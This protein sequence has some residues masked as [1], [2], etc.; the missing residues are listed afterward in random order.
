MRAILAALFI[1]VAFGFGAA[2]APASVARTL[3]QYHPGCNRTADPVGGD[4]AAASHRF[5]ERDV[6][7]Q[8]LG[9]VSGRGSGFRTLK[10]ACVRW[11][12]YD[13]V[14][15]SELRNLHADC[16]APQNAARSEC[17]AAVHRYCERV[18]SAKGGV[19][20]EI[21]PTS[22]AV[23]CASSASYSDVSYRHLYSDASPCR[24]PS[25]G[26]SVMCRAAA[27]SWCLANALG[28]VGLPQEV[29]PQSLGIACLPGTTR[30]IDLAD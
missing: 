3:T 23:A 8:S 20:Q 25:M 15:Y 16:V 13:N 30:F 22:V 29:G 17:V 6:I 5:C 26:N 11:T 1:L 28:D 12:S 14:P 18:H 24:G 9:F 10:V 27:S 2:P 21:G 7:P 4:C 19:A